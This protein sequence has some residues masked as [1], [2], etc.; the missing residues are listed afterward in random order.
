MVLPIVKFTDD[1]FSFI[2]Y[3][4]TF[5]YAVTGQMQCQRAEWDALGFNTFVVISAVQK[6]LQPGRG[7]AAV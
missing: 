7:K 1:V 4:E 5:C 3:D 2:C 6:S